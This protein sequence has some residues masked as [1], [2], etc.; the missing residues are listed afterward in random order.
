MNSVPGTRLEVCFPVIFRKSILINQQKTLEM[1]NLN[2]IS[3][4][5]VKLILLG[6][7]QGKL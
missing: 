4:N 3:P 2:K 6:S 5:L 1:H 7:G